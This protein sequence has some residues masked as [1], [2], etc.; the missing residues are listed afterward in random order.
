M[1]RIPGKGGAVWMVLIYEVA[2]KFWDEILPAPY[3]A[4]CHCPNLS[5]LPPS[6]TGWKAP[7]QDREVGGKWLCS[8][9]ALWETWGSCRSLC[10]RKEV[11]ETVW[12]LL[13]VTAWISF[14]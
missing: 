2:S 7:K 10:S 1:D 5:L 13:D 6:C 3:S 9:R 11:G 12:H 4:I 8:D 14:G